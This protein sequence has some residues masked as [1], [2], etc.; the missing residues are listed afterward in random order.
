VKDF[1]IQTMFFNSGST[2]FRDL[3]RDRVQAGIS[4]SVLLQVFVK[5]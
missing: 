1:K 2:V 4:G 5:S 3:R